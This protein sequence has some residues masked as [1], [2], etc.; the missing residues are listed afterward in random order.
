[1]HDALR[2]AGRVIALHPGLA[3]TYSAS[4]FAGARWMARLQHG[5]IY[6]GG[7]RARLG[8]LRRAVALL[9]CA[10]LP[11]VLWARGAAALPAQRR[12]DWQAHGWLWLLA[13][14]WSAG[15]AVGI[16]FGRGRSLQAWQ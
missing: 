9:K 1:M 15:E 6:G 10:V 7:L 8:A 2:A 3:V 13:L 16:A 14:A 5:R 11:A 4:D 12:T